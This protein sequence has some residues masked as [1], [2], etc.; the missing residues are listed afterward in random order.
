MNVKTMSV[1]ELRQGI[2]VQESL[3]E[4]YKRLNHFANVM[5]Y[6]TSEYVRAI[7]F[8]VVKDNEYSELRS[9]YGN[10]IFDVDEN[11]L[12]L[13]MELSHREDSCTYSYLGY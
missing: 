9:K 4:S 2:K 3:L 12:N 13:K 10:R 7:G 5:H 11:L 8:S 1:K 6:S